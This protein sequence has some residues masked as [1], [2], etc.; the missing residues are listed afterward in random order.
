MSIK[1]NIFS[2]DESPTTNCSAPSISPSSLNFIGQKPF[3]IIF[4]I[5]K[6]SCDTSCYNK[7]VVEIKLYNIDKNINNYYNLVVPDDSQLCCDG[8]EDNT[9]YKAI[10]T[11]YTTFILDDLIIRDRYSIESSIYTILSQP[12]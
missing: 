2:Q 6:S 3:Q 8:C 12:T 4:K 1:F 9:N 7:M 11:Y 5:T 10:D